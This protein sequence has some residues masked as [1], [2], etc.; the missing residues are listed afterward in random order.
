MTHVIDEPALM[1][2]EVERDDRSDAVRLADAAMCQLVLE[3]SNLSSLDLRA[4]L[5]AAVRRAVRGEA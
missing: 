1:L 4:G 3:R 2:S 5:Y